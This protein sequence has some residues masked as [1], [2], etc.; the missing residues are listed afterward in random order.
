MTTES[1]IEKAM[2]AEG[3]TSLMD[4][5]MASL[6][7][8]GIARKGATIEGSFDLIVDMEFNSCVSNKMNIPETYSEI[9]ES[10][11]AGLAMHNPELG[12]GIGAL[13]IPQALSSTGR[14]WLMDGLAVPTLQSLGI[15]RRRESKE[16]E[17]PRP[18]RKRCLMDGLS[19]PTLQSV[20]IKRRRETNPGN[21][22]PAKR[23]CLMD[24]L[25]VPTLQSVGLKL[26]RES[27]PAGRRR[28]MDAVIV[29][30][31]RS[32]GLERLQEIGEAS[33]TRR[34]QRSERLGAGILRARL[35]SAGIGTQPYAIDLD[36]RIRD[37]SVR[38]DFM[39]AHYGG[40]S[41]TVFPSI[42]E[43]KYKKTGH[44]YFMYPNL[45]QNPDAPAIPGSHGL[46]L[47]AIGR[48]AKDSTVEWTSETYKVL[49][50]R[51]THDN[52]YM[53]DYVIKPAESLT[54]AEWAEKPQAM[55][56]RWCSKLAEKD[57][58]RITRT[59]IALRRQLG[60]N[61]TAREVDGA[62]EKDQ[63]FKNITSN[64]I[65][66]AFDSGDER[67]A[68][69]IMECVGYDEQFQRDLARKITGW[70][71]PTRRTRRRG[72]A[73]STPKA[74]KTRTVSAVE[75]RKPKSTASS[76]RGVPSNPKRL[77]TVESED[78]SD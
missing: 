57:W 58:G 34:P 61:P 2:K 13:I 23:R 66:Q 10:L 9:C 46:F 15:Q 8:P 28:S 33:S 32:L 3:V 21:P 54:L 53:G 62:I 19:V 22:R 55:R 47:S 41:Y 37:V 70:V 43:D 77:A 42:A 44:R 45:V 25:V 29:P 12:N 73:I 52:L 7:F 24:G 49:T 1:Q 69:W 64:D 26:H 16:A 59:R 31:L 30:T 74:T 63:E 14:R 76:R 5:P 6:C 50:R 39:G 36:A 18:A 67:L 56:Y 40:N 78:E 38:R 60:R 17:A 75:G 71:P 65:S 68:V 35:I 48:S 4:I 72:R 51:G 11:D 20:G 27:V